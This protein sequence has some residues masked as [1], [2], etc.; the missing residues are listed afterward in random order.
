MKQHDQ[1]LRGYDRIITWQDCTKSV[2][3]R[4]KFKN[5]SKKVNYFKNIMAMFYPGMYNDLG[6]K[7]N[8]ANNRMNYLSSGAGFLPSTASTRHYTNHE[9]PERHAVMI[10]R[11]QRLSHPKNKT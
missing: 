3:M 9:H 8:P 2:L 10:Q 6:R 11:T 5:M 1:K 7:K 4:S